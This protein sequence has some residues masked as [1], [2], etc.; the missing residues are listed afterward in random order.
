[1]FGLLKK[2]FGKKS[3]QY[4]TPEGRTV[5]EKLSSS[6]KKNEQLMEDIFKDVDILRKREIGNAHDR[7]LRYCIY[8]CDGVVNSDAINENLIKSLIHAQITPSPGEDFVNT[9]ITRIVEICEAKRTGDVQEIVEAVVYGNTILFIDGQDE[10]VLLDTKAF[11]TR[12]VNEPDNERVLLGPREGFTESVMSNL[13][14]IRRRALTSDLKMKLLTLGTR[15]RTKVF[16]CYMESLVNKQVLD[17]LM[18]KLQ[19]IDID[20]ILDAHYITE[21]IDEAPWSPFRT[22]GYTERPD[23]VMGKL[24]EGRI[25]IFVDGTP[26][27]LT[28]P[29]LFIENFQSGEDYYMSFYYSSFSRFLRIL[30]FVLTITVPGLYISVA[31]FHQ[32]MFPL[33]LFISIVAERASVPLPASLEAFAML[34]I[35]DILRETGARMPITIGQTLSIVGALVVGQAA[36]E[37]RLVAAPMVIVIALTGITGLL[38]PK[39]NAPAVYL[40]LGLLLLSTTFGFFGLLVGATCIIIHLLNLYSCGVPHLMISKKLQYQNVK[41][42]FFRAPWWQMIR[43][44]RFASDSVRQNRKG[45]SRG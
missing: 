20:G 8:Y 14:L 30:G 32:E 5:N 1:M 29:Y 4:V 7:R 28:V 36:V 2:L 40:R 37:A 42:T 19:S 24:L 44:P 35:F 41:D 38:V 22:V 45:A 16:V 13:S 12:N 15:T 10:A 21:L 34:I 39:L 17:Y 11:Q 31:A 3:K 27:V 33:Q 26:M 43:R 6:L 18:K 25:A 9:V 23:V